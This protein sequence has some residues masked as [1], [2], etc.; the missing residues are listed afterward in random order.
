MQLQSNIFQLF[1]PLK[2]GQLF[3][4]MITCL[5]INLLKAMNAVMTT[6]LP[7]FM[8]PDL[9]LKVCKAR[10]FNDIHLFEFFT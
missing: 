9:V 1:L 7:H 3:V 2:Y 10:T 6:H 5:A 4:T 8:V